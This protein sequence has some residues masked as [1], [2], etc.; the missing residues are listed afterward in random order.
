M[1][2]AQILIGLLIT[3]STMLPIVYGEE[4]TFVVDVDGTPTFDVDY[5]IEGG[6]I[7]NMSLGENFIGLYVTI[8]TTNNGTLTVD[9]L[10]E[11][12]WAAEAD[13]SDADFL[14]FISGSRV[15]FVESITN[16]DFRQLVI[17]FKVGDPYIEIIGTCVI[18]GEGCV[19][20]T[21]PDDPPIED[22]LIPEWVKAIAS[23]WVDGSIVDEE[24]IDALTFLIDYDIIQIEGYGKIDAIIVEEEILPMELTIATDKE[25]YTGGETMTIYGTIQ[26][27]K[28]EE[29]V[30]SV[31]R[32]D[33]MLAVMAQIYTNDV[34][35]YSQSIEIGGTFTETGIYIV[36]SQYRSETVEST[37]NYS[38]E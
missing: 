11:F 36:K 28:M 32:P 38:V 12:V 20:P 29:L 16:T 24:F 1:N 25:S 37:I 10:R 2:K 6:T 13:G 35:E 17:D 30:I 23:F 5:T 31:I 7:E 22:S 15:D 14:V 21:I 34:G 3:L 4:G 33:G 26:Y 18:N 27:A 19:Q 8:N 9:L